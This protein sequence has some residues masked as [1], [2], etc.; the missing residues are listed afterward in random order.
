MRR[1]RQQTPRHAKTGLTREKKCQEETLR[2]APSVSRSATSSTARLSTKRKS[3]IRPIGKVLDLSP[4]P[5]SPSL[6]SEVN[7]DQDSTGS[8]SIGANLDHELEPAIPFIVLEL[9]EEEEEEEEMTLNLRVGFKER[10]CK[11]LFES[12]PAAPLPVKRS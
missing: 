12:L 10:Q 2:Q 9:E 11:R 3:V 1:R 4:S 6:S 8:P 5:S 7:I